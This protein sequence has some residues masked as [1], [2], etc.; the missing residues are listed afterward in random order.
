MITH[1]Q[2][3][4]RREAA[5]GRRK[6]LHLVLHFLQ[7]EM[8]SVGHSHLRGQASNPAQRRHS[9]PKDGPGGKL[10][11]LQNVITQV[12]SK[13]GLCQQAPSHM[14]GKGPP[15]LLKPAGSISAPEVTKMAAI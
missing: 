7:L 4:L 2:L 11:S 8:Q 13:P 9:V 6:R 5:L 12:E 3:I 14:L 15:A 10:A 1:L